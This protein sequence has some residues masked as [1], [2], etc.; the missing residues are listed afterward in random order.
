VVLVICGVY[1]HAVH[2]VAILEGRGG[3]RGRLLLYLAPLIIGIILILFMVKPLF[4]RRMRKTHP[5][6]LNRAEEPTLHDFVDRLCEIVRAPK[7]TR[8][9]VDTA[10]NASASFGE[11]SL[12]FLRHDLVLTVGLPLVAGLNLRQLTGVLAHE[13]GHFAQGGAM[14]LTYLIRHINNWFARVVYERDSWDDWLANASHDGGHWG[15]TLVVALARF[16]VWVTRW[17]LWILMFMGHVVSSI[18]LRQMEYDADRYEARV[19]GS[20]TFVLTAE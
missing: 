19:A 10:V 16:F 11:G 8:I 17:I 13:F 2:D 4:A 3:G 7:P 9:D 15:I 6:T 14:R 12:S 1:W 5:L 18:M 20:E